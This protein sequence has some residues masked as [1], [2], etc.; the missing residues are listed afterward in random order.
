MALLQQGDIALFQT[1]DGGEIDA[2]D[3]VIAMSQGLEVAAYLSL[4]GGN[5]DDDGSDDSPFSWWAN[6]NETDPAKRYRSETQN[7]L[8][9]V[10][11]TT[12]VLRR[13]EDAAARDLEWFITNRVAN[14]VSVTA[15][16]PALNTIQL[17]VAIQAV[18]VETRFRFVE[19]WKAS[20]GVYTPPVGSVTLPVVEGFLLKEDDGRLIT[21]DGLGRLLVE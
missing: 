16:I 12:A 15:S 13:V 6:L 7:L 5:E 11:L 21:G 2:V 1:N 9:R 3:G 19:N 4:F 8:Y 18:G 20:I 14:T 10:P 17:D